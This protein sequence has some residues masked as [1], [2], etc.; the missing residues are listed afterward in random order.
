MD[1]E[2]L[3]EG[4]QLLQDGWEL[5]HIFVDAEVIAYDLAKWGRVL[6]R[7]FTRVYRRPISSHSWFFG[8]IKFDRYEYKQILDKEWTCIDLDDVPLYLQSFRE[9]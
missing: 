4:E 7:K 3:N 5:N 1:A 9:V 8:A 2:K 6:M